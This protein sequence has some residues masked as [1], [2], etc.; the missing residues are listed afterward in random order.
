[1]TRQ[2]AKD[3]LQMKYLEYP[4]S[5]FIKIIDVRDILDEIFDDQDRHNKYLENLADNAQNII[6]NLEDL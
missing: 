1:M 3:K 6:N 2:E 4:N 5:G